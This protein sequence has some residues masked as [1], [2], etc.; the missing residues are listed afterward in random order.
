[1]AVNFQTAMATAG[2]E[3]PLAWHFNDTLTPTPV[4]QIAAWLGKR[5]ADEVVVA[6]DAVH[7]Y[8]FGPGVA[9]RTI[10]APV[11]LATFDPD[12]VTVD[13]K[14]LR[15]DLGLPPD[16]PVVGTVGN[17]N[18]IK[19]HEYLLRAVSR[20]VRDGDHEIAVPIVG[21]PLESRQAY[22]QRLQDLRSDLGL[23]DVVHFVGFRDDI[24]EL[25][26]LFDVFVLPSVA[27]A[28]P[29]VVLEAMAM[30][31]PVVA[32]AVGG[33]PEQLPDDDHGWTVPP[34]DDA[35]LANAI[36]AAL[37]DPDER[38][39]RAKNARQRVEAV[40]SLDACVER[41]LELYRS[42]EAES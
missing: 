13:E 31:A 12:A 39:R 3:V 21:A 15:D 26:A 41:H 33:V 27:E 25:L 16:V 18:P 38:Q 29:I 17:V 11:D 19:G 36:A 34:E 28:C 8:F 22:F 4:K 30:E 6:A 24:P 35:A 1:M 7:D 9:S 40:F 23:D 32:T 10:Y 5:W 14:A 42:L 20:L 2:S 37:A